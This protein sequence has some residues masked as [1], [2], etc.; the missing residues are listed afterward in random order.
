VL[1][2]GPLRH[3]ACYE[4][5]DGVEKLFFLHGGAAPKMLVG[6]EAWTP[7]MFQQNSPYRMYVT[8]VGPWTAVQGVWQGQY[9]VAVGKQPQQEMLELVE[10]A[11]P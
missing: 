9:V 4:Y 11:L 8:H 10:S 3:W 7:Q 2:E 6:A 5:T 1:S